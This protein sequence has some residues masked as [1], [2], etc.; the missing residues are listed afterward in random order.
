MGRIP[1]DEIA[2]HTTEGIDATLSYILPEQPQPKAAVKKETKSAHFQMLLKPST[3]AKAEAWAE[4]MDL[5]LNQLVNKALTLYIE[6]L[7]KGEK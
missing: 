7:E 1:L 3:K 4:Q 2:H 5:S 6:Q